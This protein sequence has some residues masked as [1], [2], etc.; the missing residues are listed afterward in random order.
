MTEVSPKQ[1][2]ENVRAYWKE[3]SND[4]TADSVGPASQSPSSRQGSPGRGV[5]PR[6]RAK[7]YRQAIPV[8]DWK[9]WRKNA[10]RGGGAIWTDP[11]VHCPPELQHWIGRRP[12]LD[13]KHE[14]YVQNKLEEEKRHNSLRLK[15]TMDLKIHQQ[16]RFQR[17]REHNH[18][19][20]TGQVPRGTRPATAPTVAGS[21]S[22]ESSV[23]V[24]MP[25]RMTTEGFV[26]KDQKYYRRNGA[27]W[28]DFIH[29][30]PDRLHFVLNDKIID[31][32]KRAA[33][34]IRKR[35]EEDRL[36]QEMQQLEKFERAREIRE[37]HKKLQKYP[38]NIA[39]ATK[40]DKCSKRV[41][42]L[43]RPKTAADAY[44]EAGPL[45]GIDFQ[46]LLVVDKTVGELVQH[47]ARKNLRRAVS[48]AHSKQGE[49]KQKADLFDST[50]EV[51]QP[52][53]AG[54]EKPRAHTS[55]AGKRV[56]KNDHH[57]SVRPTT[58]GVRSRQSPR[59][60]LGPFG[61]PVTAPAYAHAQ[62]PASAAG[63]NRG[64]G[65]VSMEGVVGSMEERS[66]VGAMMREVQ[67]TMSELETFEERS[68][69]VARR[70]CLE[71]PENWFRE[72]VDRMSS[73]AKPSRVGEARAQKVSSRPSTAP[74]D[75]GYARRGRTIGR[76]S[77]N[78]NWLNELGKNKNSAT[79]DKSDKSSVQPKESNYWTFLN[80]KKNQDS[81]TTSTGSKRSFLN[82]RREKLMV[83]RD[84]ERARAE[85]QAKIRADQNELN[86]LLKK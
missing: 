32:D 78:P 14:E 82:E 49:K 29:T 38:T 24:E 22:V 74:N 34:L 45:D 6:K 21:V 81:S 39:H 56:R 25:P 44:A 77:N 35:Y 33:D 63:S 9:Y 70:I 8:K 15:R 71:G 26:V 12:D 46:G 20:E 61:R 10:Y 86:R 16:H 18:L 41:E 5:R 84:K 28:T 64:W 4:D 79:V 58:T 55:P 31:A 27:M 57:Y 54:E 19:V 3:D 2:V 53:V 7:D 42:E 66:I 85:E 50:S 30:V 43:A 72:D 47:R 48:M 23:S 1:L 36:E 52:A 40:F 69:M 60:D 51:A 13:K 59:K 67:G 83:R 62:R 17:Q 73:K 11:S 76:E 80:S 37:H 75:V 68:K 65:D